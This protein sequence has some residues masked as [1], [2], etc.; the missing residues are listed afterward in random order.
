MVLMVLQDRRH[1]F[2]REA[3]VGILDGLLQIETLNRKV[4]V[5][6]AIRAAGGLPPVL[7]WRPAVATPRWTEQAKA[8]N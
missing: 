2:D 1:R 7:R 6:I 5:A 8:I 3:A 4:V